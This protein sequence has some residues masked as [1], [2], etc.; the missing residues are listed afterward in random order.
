MHS[1]WSVYGSVCII[2]TVLQLGSARVGGWG[3]EEKSG[4]CLGAY[5][6]GSVVEFFL[7]FF[8]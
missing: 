6:I 3:E 7:S 8:S 4:E 2:Y 1:G 5:H